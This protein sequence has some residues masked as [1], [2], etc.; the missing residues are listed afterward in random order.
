MKGFSTFLPLRGEAGGDNFGSMRKEMIFCGVICLF[1]WGCG[2]PA[3]PSVEQGESG[4][5]LQKEGGG[6]SSE[7][8]ELADTQQQDL[9]QQQFKQ[10]NS[11]E[12]IVRRLHSEWERRQKRCNDI[13]HLQLLGKDTVEQSYGGSGPVIGLNFYEHC[14]DKLIN[15]LFFDE[16]MPFEE[17]VEQGTKI[18]FGSPPWYPFIAEDVPANT[19]AKYIPS[20]LTLNDTTEEL[21]GGRILVTSGDYGKYPNEKYQA[22]RYNL[23]WN[24][25]PDRG[26]LAWAVGVIK[27]FDNRGKL[28][29]QLEFEGE[30]IG[31]MV[32]SL[33]G[34]YLAYQ[35]SNKNPDFSHFETK[36]NIYDIER[37]SIVW[38]DATDKLTTEYG[39][40]L[41]PDGVGISKSLDRNLQHYNFT[42]FMLIPGSQK[43][44]SRKFIEKRWLNG[45]AAWLNDTIY[46]TGLNLESG[47]RDNYLPVADSTGF[48]II[49][50]LKPPRKE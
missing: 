28:Y 2:A 29:H 26:V 14:T 1:F 49:D 15:Q 30:L 32:I 8:K 39:I 38:S 50:L 42:I 40:H 4:S 46:N 41:Q 43:L 20:H 34:R 17:L 44:Y 12:E 22:V 25:Y 16:H 13:R 9:N 21:L 11:G 27:L 48:I 36:V 10:A 19:L 37:K 35:T 18:I 23:E 24:E 7:K 33:D 3:K 5:I 47:K 45:G 6:I 31:E